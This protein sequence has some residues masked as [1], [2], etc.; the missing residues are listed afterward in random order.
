MKGKGKETTK[1]T[2]WEKYKT[3]GGVS[4]NMSVPSF[5]YVA[6]HSVPFTF[7]KSEGQEREREGK[8]KGK[9]SNKRK[10]R[11]GKGNNR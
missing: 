9:K 2:L 7:P 4:V 11:N 8:M 6:T 1:K 10:E 5:I 3:K